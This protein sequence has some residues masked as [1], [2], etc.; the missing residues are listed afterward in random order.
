MKE[1]SGLKEQRGG[2]GGGGKG[3]G[4]VRLGIGCQGKTAAL[5]PTKRRLVGTN[6]FFIVCWSY[7]IGRKVKNSHK[8]TIAYQYTRLLYIFNSPFKIEISMHGFCPQPDAN[9]RHSD[10]I[11]YI[12][13]IIIII[14]LTWYPR[15]LGRSGKIIEWEILIKI[16]FYN[17]FFHVKK[18]KK[19]EWL[20]HLFSGVWLERKYWKQ[21]ISISD[22]STSNK[23]YIRK[24]CYSF[25]NNS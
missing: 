10:L 21:L 22:S 24:N 5:Y 18:L 9:F 8:T 3:G 1:K 20:T 25:L 19:T 12:I 13:T 15:C 16:C 23:A 2:G 7:E 4:C 14:K 11:G 6:V 17:I